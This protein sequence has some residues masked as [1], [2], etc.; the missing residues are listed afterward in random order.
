MLTKPLVLW[1]LPNHLRSSQRSR[2]SSPTKIL[3]NEYGLNASLLEGNGPSD[4][5]ATRSSSLHMLLTAPTFT[6]HYLWRKFDDAYMRPIFGGRH[7][8]SP[9]GEGQPNDPNS[10]TSVQND[11][12]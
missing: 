6:V 5:F 11:V 8:G 7:L 4:N 9:L 10:R 3:I 2:S 12:A 1:I